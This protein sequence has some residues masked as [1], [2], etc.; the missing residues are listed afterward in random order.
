ME[1]HLVHFNR[2]FGKTFK[3]ASEKRAYNSL[4]VLG[5]MFEIQKEDNPKL[6][7]FIDSKKKT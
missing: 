3:K 7:P 1:L 4:T 2:D 5:V 6:Q